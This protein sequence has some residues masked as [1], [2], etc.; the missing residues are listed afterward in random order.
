MKILAAATIFI[1]ALSL[2]ANAQLGGLM[3]KASEK[4]V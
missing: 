4:V 2:N 1:M 3:N